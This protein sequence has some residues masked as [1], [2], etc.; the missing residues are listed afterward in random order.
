[1]MAAR[2]LAK[3]VEVFVEVPIPTR[4]APPLIRGT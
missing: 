4:Y 1:M 2:G 3:D